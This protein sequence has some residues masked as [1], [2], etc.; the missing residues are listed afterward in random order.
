MNDS[1]IEWHFHATRFRCR[2]CRRDRWNH[3][4]TP[5][6]RSVCGWAQKIKNNTSSNNS[7]RASK[8]RRCR[9]HPNWN[10][11]NRTV[12]FPETI[13]STAEGFLSL[14]PVALW[15]AMSLLQSSIG[16]CLGSLSKHHR[17]Q[18]NSNDVGHPFLDRSI[19]VFRIWRNRC[20]LN[21]MSH[22]SFRISFTSAVDTPTNKSSAMSS[23]SVTTTINLQAIQQVEVS[24]ECAGARMTKTIRDVQKNHN[25]ELTP[26]DTDKSRLLVGRH[27]FL[28]RRDRSFIHCA[29]SSSRQ[30]LLASSESFLR[31][32][33]SLRYERS[34][35]KSRRHWSSE[36]L[37]ET[38]D[39]FNG[40]ERDA[41]RCSSWTIEENLF[42]YVPLICVI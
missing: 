35:G 5:K 38:F 16:D 3:R 25:F 20:V 24:I 26:N 33:S 21:G 9:W 4:R 28:S 34:G 31:S 7:L 2:E 11:F 13:S 36:I 6:C 18:W 23:S 8:C 39:A 32:K 22:C 12:R 29:E 37:G 41:R 40:F 42:R 15:T 10:S 19:I 1:P 17:G 27:S 30:S 14:R